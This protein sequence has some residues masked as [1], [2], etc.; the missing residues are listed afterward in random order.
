MTRRRKDH[1]T[2]HPIDRPRLLRLALQYSVIEISRLPGAPSAD[3]IYREL[4]SD[5]AL[6]REFARAN[7][8]QN[9]ARR[10]ELAD[11]LKRS[12]KTDLSR[13][14]IALR[15]LR[16][17]AAAIMSGSPPEYDFNQ[18]SDDELSQLQNILQKALLLS[19]DAPDAKE[20]QDN[21]EHH[22]TQT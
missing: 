5:A 16:E 19:A 3:I 11:L 4:A 14:F 21:D 8:V 20:D 22:A 7:N 10:A 12:R 9:H 15:K 6:E 2:S 18:L 1:P 13:I 17:Q